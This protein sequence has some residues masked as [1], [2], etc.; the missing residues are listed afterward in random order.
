MTGPIPR[1][2]SKPPVKF[3]DLLATV[4]SYRPQA[5]L[6]VIERAWEFSGKA[7]E[8]QF[9]LTGDPYV[10]H[11]L[12]VANILAELGLDETTLAAALLHDVVEDTPTPL[13]AI[14]EAFGEEI[15]ELVDGVT[16]ISRIDFA[17][18]KLR[19]AEN[20]RRMFLA[21][22]RD[23]RVIIIKLADRLHNLRTLKPLPAERRRAVAE[24]T[25]QIF[26]PIAHRLGLWRLKWELED[27]ALRYLEPAKYRQIVHL[28]AKSRQ[29]REAR[30]HA[31]VEQLSARLAEAGIKAEAFGR[32]KHFYSI[33]QK[34]KTQ[35]V[36]FSQ[37][38]DVEAIR[39]IVPTVQD[40]YT[41]LGVAHSLWLPMRDMFTDYIAKPKPNLYQSLHTK[42]L[43]PA[44]NPMEVQIRTGKMH[45][46]AEYGIAA[47]WLYKEGLGPQK[48]DEKLAWVRRLIELHTDFSDPGEWLES[49]KLDLFKDQVFVF[50]PNGDVIDLPAG[51][52]AVDFAYR[53]HTELGHSCVGTKVN[54]KLVPL[55]YVFKNGDLVE[56]LTSKTAR[57]P[58]LD[59][60]S[61]VATSTAKSRIKAWFR[62]QNREENI[63]HGRGLLEAECK[64]QSLSPPQ[65]L[66]GDNLEALSQKTNYLSVEDLLAAVGLGEMSAEAAVRRITGKSQPHPTAAPQTAVQGTLQLGISAPG[67]EGILFRLSRCC[68]P[69][70]GDEI[71]G[72]VTR[73]RGVT[74]HRT[75]CHNIDAY[76]RTDPERLMR[77]E[78]SLS[79]HAVY[80]VQIEIDALDRVGLLNDITG[81]IS[82]ANTN[83]RSARVST[84]RD[85][86]AVFSLVLDISDLDHLNRLMR[87][88]GSLSDVLRVY[89]LKSA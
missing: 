28:V 71:I 42:V 72:Y 51:A 45:R 18:S 75:D 46:T 84:K 37:I 13:S 1:A 26:A 29:D 79:Q 32:P 35:G 52:T 67:A 31:A 88:I 54:G 62:R 70:P 86:R 82:A 53:I 85:R 63:A 17:A 25:L 47:H 44:G 43:G 8:G 61:F 60:L 74:V 66:S 38:L 14:T 55:N 59:W 2:G 30:I 48:A 6:G 9:R 27:L 5:D 65:I 40:C 7:H 77:V 64:R 80:P 19:Q 39:V 11:P 15:A 4:K 76:Q 16:K 73:G 68:C 78:W 36:D 34:M 24:E 87:D 12:A 41:A 83:I 50:T 81:I 20:L 89:R 33:Y 22:A 56:I 49:L 58:S 21:M 3:D 57:G 10:S 69:V 23:L